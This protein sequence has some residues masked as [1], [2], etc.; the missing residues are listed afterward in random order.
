MKEEI[1]EITNKMKKTSQPNGVFLTAK[2]RDKIIYY[3][4]NSLEE[5]ERLNNIIKEVREYIESYNLPK[6]LGHLGEAPISIRELRDI[7]EILD[8]GE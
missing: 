4:D 2:T 7:L 5:I 8:K 3:I 6:D 1:K